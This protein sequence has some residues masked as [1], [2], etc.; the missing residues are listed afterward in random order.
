MSLSRPGGWAAEGRAGSE[1]DLAA[2]AGRAAFKLPAAGRPAPARADRDRQR[3]A[4]ERSPMA[5]TR[6]RQRIS[7]TFN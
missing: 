1:S 7:S 4:T 5:S 6:V 3:A 2:T